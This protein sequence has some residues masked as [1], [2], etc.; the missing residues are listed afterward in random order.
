MRYLAI[1]ILFLATLAGCTTPYAVVEETDKFADP[2]K[3]ARYA[4]RSNDILRNE[5][6]ISHGDLLDP[7]VERDRK[8]GKVISTGFVLLRTV[9]E[10]ELIWIGAPKWLGIRPGDEIE[11][12]ADGERIAFKAVSARTYHNFG[13]YNGANMTKYFD[14]AVYTSE[15]QQFAKIANAKNIEIKVN[16]GNGNTVYPSNNARMPDSFYE[17][18]RRFYIE[19]V[20]PFL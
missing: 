3:P 2:N 9:S 18:L 14:Q 1:S 20:E 15:P 16:G 12:L 6:G 7:Y 17:N 4:L 13:Y 10:P 19:Q 8:T 5:I 11:F